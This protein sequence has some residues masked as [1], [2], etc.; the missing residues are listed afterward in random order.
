MRKKKAVP[1]FIRRSVCFRSTPLQRLW[2]PCTNTTNLLLKGQQP[3]TDRTGPAEAP[4]RLIR[5][6]TEDTIHNQSPN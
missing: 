6:L 1:L 3:H 4:R 5:S 2:F